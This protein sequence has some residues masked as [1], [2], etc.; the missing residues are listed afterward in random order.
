MNQMPGAG[1]NFL[2]A[3]CFFQTYKFFLKHFIDIESLKRGSPKYS[4]RNHKNIKFKHTPN[5]NNN[6]R[7]RI[8]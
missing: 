7:T 8:D 2:V 1:F 4:N 3:F 6:R 5:S